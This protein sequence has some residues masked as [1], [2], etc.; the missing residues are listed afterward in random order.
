MKKL[1]FIILLLTACTAY[2]QVKTIK[3][4]LIEKKGT[5]EERIFSNMK[6]E[7]TDR[8][9][10]GKTDAKGYFILKNVTDED[11]I[12]IYPNFTYT[13]KDVTE[14]VIS[15]I[16]LPQDLYFSDNLRNATGIAYITDSA[17]ITSYMGPRNKIR[18]IKKPFLRYRIENTRTKYSYYGYKLSYQGYVDMATVG[19]MP[20]LQSE[21]AQGQNGKWVGT[22]MNE[23]FSWGPAI[24]TLEYKGS[25]LYDKNGW[26]TNKGTG[27]G[28][29]ANTYDPLKFYRTGMSFGNSVNVKFASLGSGYTSMSISQKKYNSP[30]PNAY[31]EIYNMSLQQNEM[32]FDQFKTSAGV[33][34]NSSYAKLKQY[35]ANL[36]NLMY[37]V[38]TTPPTFDN[39]NGLSR[40]Q[41]LK[42]NQ[43]WLLPDGMERSYA[44]YAAN[45]PFGLVAT[46]PDRDKIDNLV[47]FAKTKYEY[48][49]VIASASVSFDKQWDK[50]H[51]GQPLYPYFRNGY[52]SED[53]SN[54]IATTD[55]NYQIPNLG[56]RYYNKLNLSAYYGFKGTTDKVRRND[57]YIFSA[58]VFSNIP[59]SIIDDK[60]DRRA[61]DLRYGAKFENRSIWVELNN[62]HYFSNTL[63]SNN[64]V[65]MFPELGFNWRMEDF[66][67]DTFDKYGKYFN[68]YG[69]IKRS[70]GESPLIYRNMAPLST[71]MIATDFRSYYEY[72]DIFYDKNIKPETYLKSELGLRY[73]SNNGKFSAE[74]NGFQYNTH[75][76]TSPVPS[77]MNT[78]RLQNIGRIRNYGYFVNLNYNNGYNGYNDLYYSLLLNFSQSRSTVSAIYGDQPFVRIAGFKDIAAV[79]AKDQALGAI[80]GTTYKRNE[81]GQMI[82][83]NDGFPLVDPDLKKI[84]DPT[85][86]FVMSFVPTISK[87]Q[88]TLSMAIE[89]SQGGDR[90]NGTKA[91][92][93]YRGM[94]QSSA[95]DRN[96]KGYIYNGVNPAGGTNN[97]V[98]DF[99][100]PSK[101]L[102]Q[103]KWVRYGATGVGEKYIEKA[104]YIRLANITLTYDVINTRNSGFFKKMTVSAQA[105]NLILITPYKGVDPASGLFGYSS[106][107]GLDL[108]N[109]PSTRSYSLTLAFEL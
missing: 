77:E 20:K 104:T 75:N 94:S 48:D 73:N 9:I 10:Y 43:S 70:V 38:V 86:D 59:I 5:S 100:D 71:N 27:N 83:G 13:V 41:A 16:P 97:V 99:Y 66:I 34:Y 21:Y 55:F 45:N 49:R 46:L 36:A 19:R 108:F 31:E 12:H 26:L 14:E 109:Q 44:L 53:I 65:N 15:E 63:K 47:A 17:S 107:N 2:G 39:A 23:Q 87:K 32:E 74:I 90:W 93:D 96:I 67:S 91:F 85:P 42:N 40:T 50:R 103:N 35:G 58:P 54:I 33:S 18:S 76:F 24:N 1:A 82:I 3:G 80:Y 62:N 98:V 37:S 64:Y 29:P 69:S 61:H 51:N 8:N 79:F 72:T 105:R 57:Q 28:I 52:R 106:G 78:F 102:N 89:Y 4:R 95:E 68:I 7:V 25:Y 6:F 60:L 81:Q 11:V 22:D 56:N 30:I 88:F 92:L 101:N 84:G